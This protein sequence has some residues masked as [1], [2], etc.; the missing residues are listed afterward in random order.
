MTRKNRLLEKII[1]RETILYGIVGVGTSALNIILFQLLLMT[2]LDYKYANFFTLVAVKLASYVCNKNIVFQSHTGSMTGL[3]KEFGRFIVA[4]GA[5][6]L[7][8][9]FG[10]ILMVEV[11]GI[12]KLISKCIVTVGVIIINYFTGKKHVFKD[13]MPK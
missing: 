8:D 2:G 1:N 4:R 7:I 12:R 6:M 5:T 3:I 10:L 11:L 13:C 9:Y